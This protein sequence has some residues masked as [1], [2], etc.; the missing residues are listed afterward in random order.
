MSALRA[1]A[2]P[3]RIKATH[4]RRR[5]IAAGRFVQRY[6][7]PEIG[8]FLIP[9]PVGPEE[10]FVKHFN[11]YSYVRNNPVHY[12]DPDGRF[13]RSY[14]SEYAPG[15]DRLDDFDRDG[16]YTIVGHGSRGSNGFLITDSRNPDMKDYLTIHDLA[17]DIRADWTAKGK[18]PIF[19]SICLMG[20]EA[21]KLSDD[22][23]AVVVSTKGYASGSLS[24]TNPT[25]N[26]VATSGDK[27]TGSKMRFDVY[28]PGGGGK[29]VASFSVFTMKDGSMRAVIGKQTGSHIVKNIK[30]K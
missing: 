26:L 9:D 17:K 8:R 29:P 24:N 13:D 12:V 5:K 1:P 23:G 11:R 18:Q 7:D 27:G 22:L 30:I 3:H 28:K 10:D 19:N 15:K 2:N 20:S 4:R 21:Q 14:L 6:Y 16:W 25:L